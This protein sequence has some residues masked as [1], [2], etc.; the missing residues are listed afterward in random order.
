MRTNPLEGKR[1][2]IDGRYLAAH[3]SG[4]ARYTK[5]LV[6]H[7][8]ALRQGIDL[9]LIVRND[10]PFDADLKDAIDRAKDD[11]IEVIGTSAAHYSPKE[12][13]ELY[14]L[15]SLLKP[16]LVHFTNFNHPVRYSK[17]FVVTI[18]DLTLHEYP[19]RAS[20]L[21][22]WVYR[23]IMR[24]A[25]NRSRLI[26]TVSQHVKRD[27]IK[28]YAVAPSKVMVTYNGIDLEHFRPISNSKR[29]QDVTKKYKITKP[30]ILYVGQWMEHKNL[31]RL[32]E[33]FIKVNANS[34]YAGRYQLVLAGQARD[35]GEYRDKISQV[36]AERDI[37]LP[38]FI[39][40]DD[41]PALYN[42]AQLFAFPSLAE[43]FG[44]P[45][46]EA[47]ACGTPVIASRASS[48][49]EVLGQAALYFDPLDT[50]SMA[51][52]IIRGLSDAS[53]R[54]RL[55]KIGRQQAA[56]YSW[57]TTAQKTVDSYGKAL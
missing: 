29:L 28:N 26:L 5:E 43:G 17:P 18:H 21:K 34:K 4:L 44:I 19:N 1:V 45:P 22:Q 9:K 7:I 46:L 32:I 25:I 39:A 57:Q 52:A 13:T 55:S 10:E 53:L 54:E 23:Y 31:F 47:M 35:Y 49:P 50:G 15:I 27:I 51:R 30:F 3:R 6:K 36:K 2:V 12:Q 20:R 38:G 14:K 33:A 37:V 48:L 24:H 56:Q 42:A 40:D 16:D 8:I 11:K 41:L